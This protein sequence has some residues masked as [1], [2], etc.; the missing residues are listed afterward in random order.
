VPSKRN[1]REHTLQLESTPEIS[2]IKRSKYAQ[3]E[4]TTGNKLRAEIIQ[5]GIKTKKTKNKQTN[6]QTNKKKQKKKPNYTKN[7]QTQEL[8]L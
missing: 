6:K 4:Y 5:V 8:D 1:W 3:E 7:Q 2:R